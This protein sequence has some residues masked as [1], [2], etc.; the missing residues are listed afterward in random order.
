MKWSL[1]LGRV[2]G[3][4]ILV[5]W[6]FVLLLGW[7][8]FREAQRGSD[9]NTTLLAMGFVLAVFFCVVLHELGH[10]LTAQRFGINTKT[11][12]LLPIG[13]VASLERMPEKPRKEL[14]IAIAGPAV[15]VVIA[16]ILWLLLPSLQNVPEEEF[17]VQITPANFLYLLLFV[18]VVLVL[19]NAIPAFPMDGGRVLRALLA[20]KLGRVRATQIAANLG[21][22]LA[23]G[24]VFVGFLYNPF[25]IL[26]GAFVFFGAYSENILVQHLDY[27]RGHSVR[28]GM[29]TNFV[30]LNPTDTVRD[31]LNKLLMGSEHEFIVEEEGQVVGTLTRSQ[32]IQAVKEEQME[33]PVAHIMSGEFTAFNVQDKL[34]EAYTELQKTKA[35][36]YP[37]LENGKLAGVINTDNINEFIMIKSALTH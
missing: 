31:A 2:A 11:I 34:S 35:P 37:V 15:N 21:Q 22:L 1:T 6:T 12:T 14:L 36:L 7:V 9:L 32:L 30:T 28:E 5:H 20:F 19:F 23:I 3:I 29:M 25:L 8:A 13:G 27:L 24:F 17:F 33:T 4:K 26:I 16:L 10:S 18:N